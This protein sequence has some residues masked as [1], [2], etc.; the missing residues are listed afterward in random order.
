MEQSLLKATELWSKCSRE[1]LLQG[2][3]ALRK[4][5]SKE[6]PL[7]GKT[8]PKCIR[9]TENLLGGANDKRPIIREMKKL[10]MNI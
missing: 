10:Q 1:K 2:E 9:F 8:T 3:T 5:Y 4:N 6:K 7:Q